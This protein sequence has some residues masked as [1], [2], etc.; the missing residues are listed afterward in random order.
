MKCF[1]FIVG[2][3]SL[4]WNV[5]LGVLGKGGGS[6][7]MYVVVLLGVGLWIDFCFIFGFVFGGCC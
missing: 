6:Y 1:C 2:V 7:C 5:G 3:W 4:V